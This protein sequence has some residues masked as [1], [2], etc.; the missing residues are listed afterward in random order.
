MEIT[1]TDNALN[2]WR[3]V[4]AA[5]RHVHC[6]TIK[7]TFDGA[8]DSGQ[9]EDIVFASATAVIPVLPISLGECEIE[10]GSRYHDGKW[11]KVITL[12][13]MS[14]ETAVETIVYDIL[15]RTYGGWEIN[16]GSYGEINFNVETGR[17]TCCL[18]TRIEQIDYTESTFEYKEDAP[19]KAEEA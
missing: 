2:V 10:T 15:N 7:V 1:M 17:I 5:C 11:S 18:S 16:A 6:V 12:Q 8:G 14:I 4:I 13:E 19:D 3:K 9:V